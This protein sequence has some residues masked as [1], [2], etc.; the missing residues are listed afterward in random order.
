MARRLFFVPEIRRDTAEL[1]G[2]AAQHLVR[3]L[4]VEEGQQFEISDNL[5]RYLDTVTTARKSLVAFAVNEKLPDPPPAP[6]VTLLASLFKFD[7][8]EWM[9]EK[10]TELNVARIVPG[11][12]ERSEHGLDKAAPKRME[13]WER[14]VLEAS[15]Q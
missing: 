2:D 11:I 4:R 14:I 13:R 1:T 5:H 8:F 7:H 15:Q 12:A 9:L 10:A 3:V 6:N